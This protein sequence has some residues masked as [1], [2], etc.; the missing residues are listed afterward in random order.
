MRAI[1]LD[2]DGRYPAEPDRI[3]DLFQLPVA[4]GLWPLNAASLRRHRIG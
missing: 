2:R 4:L 1:L 3:T